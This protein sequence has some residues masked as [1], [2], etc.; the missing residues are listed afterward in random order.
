M[1]SIGNCRRRNAPGFR[2]RGPR[3]PPSRG[4]LSLAVDFRPK[5]EAVKTLEPAALSEICHCVRSAADEDH[6]PVIYQRLLVGV[7]CLPMIARPIRLVL[8]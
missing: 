4:R 2:S 8:V 5:E 6:V 3:L 7:A 1:F